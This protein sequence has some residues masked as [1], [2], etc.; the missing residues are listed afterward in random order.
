MH[1]FAF[2]SV[3]E[4]AFAC[5]CVIVDEFTCVCAYKCVMSLLESLHVCVSVCLHV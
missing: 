3:R 4:S 1:E 5:V 2:V